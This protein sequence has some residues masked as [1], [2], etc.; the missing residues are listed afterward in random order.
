VHVQVYEW[1]ARQRRPLDLAA[2]AVLEIGSL[3]INGSVRPLFADA[4]HYHGIDLVAGAGVDEVADA[5][6]WTPARRYDVAAC[7]EVL[8][9]AE[10]WRGILDV[11]WSAVAPGGLLLMSCATD[12][13]PPHSAVDGLDVRDGEYYENVSPSALRATIRSWS[14]SERAMEV[15]GGRGDLYFRAVKPR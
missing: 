4:P 3:D 6:R 15:A 12:P 13:R 8:E 9:H 1:F 10:S 2:G 5:S 14:T 11:M 7:A